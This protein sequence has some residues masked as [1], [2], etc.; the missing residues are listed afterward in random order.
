[1]YS[2][3]IFFFTAALLVKSAELMSQFWLSTVWGKLTVAVK[4]ER[5]MTG[6]RFKRVAWAYLTDWSLSFSRSRLQIYSPDH[7]SSSFPSNPSTPVGSPSPLTAQA[8]AATAGTVVTASGP[9]GRAGRAP[10][11]L[12]DPTCTFS[13]YITPSLVSHTVAFRSIWSHLKLFKYMDHIIE[14]L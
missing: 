7:T 13:L 10:V 1:M 2:V 3:S 11:C 12:S 4:P 14:N 5:E 6:C 9:T 8:G